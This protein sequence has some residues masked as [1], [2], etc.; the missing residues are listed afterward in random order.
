M[1]SILR[2]TNIF[3]NTVWRSLNNIRLLFLIF[4]FTAT[5][6]AHT[7]IR[8]EPIERLE[9]HN[10]ISVHGRWWVTHFTICTQH[11]GYYTYGVLFFDF[12]KLQCSYS[13]T[14]ANNDPYSHW[15]MICI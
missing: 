10:N 8:D 14:R 1:V 3:K 9:P 5:G 4:V 13:S 6:A 11:H 12:W 2:Y 7:R 15:I